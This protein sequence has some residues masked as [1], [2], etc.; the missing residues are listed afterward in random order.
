VDVS[1]RTLHGSIEALVRNMVQLKASIVEGYLKDKFIGFI[2]KYLHRF[3]ATQRCVWEED[4]ECRDAEEVLQEVRR[5][6]VLSPKLRDI[7]H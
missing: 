2:I 4:E 5:P 1:S 7:A 6:Y 3:K